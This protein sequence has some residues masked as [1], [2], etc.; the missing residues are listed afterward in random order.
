MELET[1]RVHSSYSYQLQVQWKVGTLYLPKCAASENAH[2][3]C[4]DQREAGHTC[5]M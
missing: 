2:F 3:C 5:T 4:G 1:S